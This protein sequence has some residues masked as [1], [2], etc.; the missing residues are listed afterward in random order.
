MLLIGVSDDTALLDIPLL[1]P[2]FVV[3]TAGHPYMLPENPVRSELSPSLW[4][5]ISARDLVFLALQSNTAD[6]LHAPLPPP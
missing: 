6:N 5:I 4:V 2:P 3:P 1:D